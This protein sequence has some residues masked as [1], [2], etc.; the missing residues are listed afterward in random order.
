M[1]ESQ[2]CF[3][4]SSVKCRPSENIISLIIISSLLK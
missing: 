3:L 1:V 2:P 4:S